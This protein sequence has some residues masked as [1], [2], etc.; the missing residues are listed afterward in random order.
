MSKRVKF[1]LK[2]FIGFSFLG[3]ISK[4][5]M[6]FFEGII[7]FSL[8]CFTLFMFFILVTS[9]VGLITNGIKNNGGLKK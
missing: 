6:I 9:V 1:F 8:L 3:V 4:C 7:N 5:L 2:C